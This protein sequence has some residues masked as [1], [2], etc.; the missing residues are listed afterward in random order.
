MNRYC[1]QVRAAPGEGLRP[2]YPNL[3]GI[4]VRTNT[5]VVRAACAAAALAMA[6]SA[7]P[8]HA[9]PPAQSVI[10]PAPRAVQD[11]GEACGFPVRWDVDI[12]K[13]HIQ[14]FFDSSGRRIRQQAH[15]TEDNTITN[16]ATGKTLR[17]GPDHFTQT[18]HYNAFGTVDRIIANGLALHVRSK[19]SVKDVGRIIWLPQTNEIV[20]AAGQHEPREAMEFGSEKDALVA[21]CDVLA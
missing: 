15:I 20:F 4:P 7:A 1:H 3:W 5:Y 2:S 16:L 21:F 13:V 17:E 8:A 9:A 12:S 11:N 14:N 10:D 18:I 19:N 6:A